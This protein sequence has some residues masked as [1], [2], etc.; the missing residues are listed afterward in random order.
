[1]VIGTF[2]S[3]LDSAIENL[4]NEIIV[5]FYSDTYPCHCAFRLLAT[6]WEECDRG[7]ERKFN[8]VY[9]TPSAPCHNVC[10]VLCRSLENLSCTNL[11][12]ILGLNHVYRVLTE[13]FRSYDDA[14]THLN[15]EIQATWSVEQC[16]DEPGCSWHK[17]NLA[18]MFTRAQGS[19][20]RLTI[21]ALCWIKEVRNEPMRRLWFVN[22]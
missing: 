8:C 4:K 9:R 17:L 1:M 15:E 13:L 21:S 3:S 19:G 5:W 7:C 12:Q 16:G 18:R 20:Q 6:L 2:T 22:N 14:L 10:S 11:I